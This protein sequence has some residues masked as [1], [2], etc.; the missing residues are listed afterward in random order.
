MKVGR[1][2]RKK[3]IE[4]YFISSC[5]RELKNVL[6]VENWEN[7]VIKIREIRDSYWLFDELNEIPVLNI[8]KSVNVC[9]LCT[10]FF[11]YKEFDEGIL[12]FEWFFIIRFTLTLVYCVLEKIWSTQFMIFWYI[13]KLRRGYYKVKQQSKDE[14]HLPHAFLANDQLTQKCTK[15][16]STWEVPENWQQII[17]V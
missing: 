12:L 4:K 3:K 9:L 16:I 1:R 14:K 8:L 17:L 2:R 5:L 7:F 13:W 10:Q 11:P 15:H 6:T